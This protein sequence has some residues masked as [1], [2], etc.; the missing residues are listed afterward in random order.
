[1]ACRYAKNQ[2]GEIQANLPGLLQT[3]T[4]NT[5]AF[6]V[7]PQGVALYVRGQP[8]PADP[9]VRQLER[10][11]TKVTAS[12]P[13]SGDKN[14]KVVNYLAGKT[15]QRILHLETADPLRT[16]TITLFPKPDYYFDATNLPC[17]SPT[18]DCTAINHA[19]AYNHGYYSPAIDV[20]W[21]S[22]VG[23]GVKR[24][25]INGR[26]PANSPLVHDPNGGGTVP[27][28]SEEG[29]WAD[30][31]DI[32]P[33]M[34][35]LTGVVDDYVFDGR[36]MSE[37]IRGSGPLH[38]LED[39][40]ACFKQLNA[41]VGT[42]GTD[43]LIAATTALGTGSAGSDSQ[44]TKVEAALLSLAD[45]R[46]V[47]ATQIKTLLDQAS[48]HGTL[49]ASSLIEQRQSQCDALVDEATALRTG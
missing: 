47:L 16:P 5:T 19:Y 20:T 43:T 14:E 13:Y 10:D 33:T 8:G 48:F 11:L 34:L 36:V 32:R 15:E 21:S 35:Y 41:S 7:E 2:V 44:Y 12:N 26:P 9:S 49:V 37:I 22:F 42:F 17:R 31:T 46:D 1:V 38:N 4:G 30:E 29:L 40:G 45:R 25:G 27:Q 6:D 18:T 39:L 28:Y 24:D 3:Q 23:P